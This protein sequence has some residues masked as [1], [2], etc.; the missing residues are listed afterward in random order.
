[1]IPHLVIGL[2]PGSYSLQHGAATEQV[3]VAT[4]VTTLQLEETGDFAFNLTLPGC[5]NFVIQATETMPTVPS[6]GD[7][8]RVRALVKNSGPSPAPATTVNLKLNGLTKTNWQI[9]ALSS[10]GTVFTPWYNFGPLPGGT[11]MV[12][13]CADPMNLVKE[14]QENDNCR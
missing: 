11:H 1:M 8:I 5:P 6:C 7:S 10:G 9:P 13:V 4:E 2:E 3:E 12:D 14:E